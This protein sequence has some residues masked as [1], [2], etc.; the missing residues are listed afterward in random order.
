MKKALEC[1]ETAL[2]SP[3]S[4]FEGHKTF[5]ALKE[6]KP[7]YVFV[8]GTANLLLKYKLLT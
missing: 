1:L 8:F 6:R 4:A 2:L 3:I 5:K 7:K